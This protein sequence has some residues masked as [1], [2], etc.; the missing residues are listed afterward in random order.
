VRGFRSAIAIFYR[1]KRELEPETPITQ[2]DQGGV[3]M[4][5]YV[6]NAFAGQQG[7]KSIKNY[8]LKKCNICANEFHPR[9]VFDRFCRSCKEESQL[10]KFSE[11]LPELDEGLTERISA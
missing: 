4:K 2:N 6:R 7:R 3:V 10:L 9:T 1:P 11:W 5:Y 8:K